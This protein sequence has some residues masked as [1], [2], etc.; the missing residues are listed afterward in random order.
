MTGPLHWSTLRN[1]AESP[2]H[3]KHYMTHR[4]K[5][6]PAMLFGTLVHFHCFGPGPYGAPVVY[7][8]TKTRSG[9]KWDAFKAAHTKR[10]IVTR[11]EWDR[12]KECAEAVRADPVA[13]AL[14]KVGKPEWTLE[15]MI[16]N[17]ACRG[18]PDRH[19]DAMLIDLKVSGVVNPSRFTGPY[20]HA[21]KQG[22]HGQMAWYNDAIGTNPMTYI[23]AVSPKPPFCP[24][25]Y[26]LTDA[27]LDSGR[28][29]Y[30]ALLERFNACDESNQW[31]GYTQSILT[32]DV[33]DDDLTLVIDGQEEQV[34]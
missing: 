7:E 4:T 3:C 31:P 34:A 19:D 9:K 13:G 20:G 30:R 5:P 28:K 33:Q 27:D 14:L 32:L 23:I 22:W 17:R 21:R 18:T 8:E 6:T 16:G 12:A 15:W 26:E 1:M 29:F 2:A 10:D 11:D 25:V 24:T